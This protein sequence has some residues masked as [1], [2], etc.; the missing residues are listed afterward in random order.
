LGVVGGGTAGS[1]IGFVGSIGC[2]FGMS[3]SG[4]GALFTGSVFAGVPVP[5]L[6]SAEPESPQAPQRS[7]AAAARA[8]PAAGCDVRARIVASFRADGRPR[9]SARRIRSRNRDPDPAGGVLEL[10][11]RG[12]SCTAP[13]EQ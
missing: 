10:D 3:G 2:S 9:A 6:P 4:S 5:G 13:G 7:A 1:S 11:A 12:E 8:N